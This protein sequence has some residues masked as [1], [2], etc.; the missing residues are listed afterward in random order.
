MI[1]YEEVYNGSHKI[2]AK[3]FKPDAPV[4]AVQVLHGMAE[5]MDRYD[6]FCTWLMA[7]DIFTVIHNHRGHGADSG[8]P[9]HFESFDEL[10]EDALCIRRLIP[11][12]LPVFILGHSMGSIA[13]R[14]LL[15]EPF[16]DGGILVGTGSRRGPLNGIL[17]RLMGGV[18]RIAPEMRGDWLTR[19]AFFG[20]DG[21]F[22]EDLPNRWLCSDMEVVA[23]YNSD[24]LCG[25]NMTFNALAE[26]VKNIRMTDAE[27]LLRRYRPD[28]PVLLIGGKEDPFSGFGRDIRVL[29]E[30]MAPH[31]GPVT[32]QLYED[33][34]HEV[35][36]EKNREQVYQKLLEWVM[37]YVDQ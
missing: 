19:L 4:A 10:T 28:I 18:K 1:S 8:D 30:K 34:R 7:N 27:D 13:A 29:A 5:H 3:V 25:R 11:P 36:K 26:I 16:Y 2:T 31:A 20:Y 12:G 14:R 17:S 33:S 21:H 9:G 37:S 23:Q 15:A 24:G 6:E 35:L 32:V 22:P